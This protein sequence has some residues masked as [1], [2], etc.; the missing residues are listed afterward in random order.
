MLLESVSYIDELPFE[1]SFLNVGEESKHC[2]KEIEILL[3]L[4]GT[5]HYQIYHTDYELNPGDL[6]IADVEDLHQIHDS[7]DDILLLSVH[8]DTGRFEHLYPNIRYMFFVCEECMEGPAGN[9]QLLE[10]KLTRLKGHI[11]RMAADYTAKNR[12]ISLL[13]EEV[14]Q[15]VSIL[16]NHFQGFFMEDYQYKTSQEDMS[17]DDLQRLSRITRY[18]MLNYKEKITLDDVSNMEHLSSYYVSHLIKKTLGFNFQNFV[19][20]I[21]LEYAEKLLVFSSMTLMQISQECGFSSPNYFNKCFSA[22]HGKTP[23]QYRKEYHPCERSFKNPFTQEEALALLTPFLNVSKQGRKPPERVTVKPDFSV[24]SFLN[25]WDRCAPRIVIDSLEAALN[26]GCYRESIQ[27]IRPAAFILDESLTRRNKDLEKSLW[28]LL[29]PLEIPLFADQIIRDEDLIAAP[30]TAAAFEQV[31][32]AGHS[33]IRLLGERNALFTAEGLRTPAYQVY[34]CFAQLSEPKFYDAGTHI[35]ISGGEV[36]AI[37]LLNTDSDAALDIHLA[38]DQ[39]PCESLLVRRDFPWNENCHNILRSLKTQEQTLPP[40]LKQR[41]NDNS[42]G[43]TR[44]FR[45]EKGHSPKDFLI[46]HN[47]A[48]IL[49]IFAPISDEGERA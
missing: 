28:K 35:L 40:L 21:R 19:N 48:S 24:K 41:I 33:R 2:H 12:N 47:S 32:Q 34:D 3:V 44:F 49:E 11:S 26:L 29:E 43:E 18:I 46:Y 17:H 20:A 13:T 4:R 22:W 45:L 23:A 37:L 36:Q 38:L 6:I 1:L 10:S 5:T 7:S 30:D 25:F 27:R 9:K 42:D 14:S 31:L 39:I 16:V 15:L 8:V